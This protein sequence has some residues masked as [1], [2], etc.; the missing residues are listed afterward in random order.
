MPKQVLIWPSPWNNRLKN[1]MFQ[2][3]YS[4]RGSYQRAFT[5]WREL[6]G[7]NGIELNTW[8][9]MPLE[10]ADVLWFIDLPTR[11]RDLDNA[12]REAPKAAAVLHIFESPVLGP[13]FF[14]A[15]NQK[16]VSATTSSSA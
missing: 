5:L 8:D 9:M 14:H 15:G 10:Q 16:N 6:A 2:S 1:A 7:R 13:Q 12:R 3:G 4:V 11:R